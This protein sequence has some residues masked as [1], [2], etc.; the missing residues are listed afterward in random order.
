MVYLLL[1][2]HETHSVRGLSL[3]VWLSVCLSGCLSVCVSVW[4]LSV[5][6]SICLYVYLSA[7]L[8]VCLARNK[9]ESEL[10]E[11]GSGLH[12]SSPYYMSKKTCPNFFFILC[13][14]IKWVKASWTD[15]KANSAETISQLKYT[16]TCIS[17][18]RSIGISKY[19]LSYIF[20][21]S[22]PVMCMFAWA[23]FLHE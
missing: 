21:D 18:K 20:F 15:S 14:Q 16:I 13:Y 7:C 12:Q 10:A 17:L 19:F 23:I 3:C 1:F 6:L 11:L 9:S 4:L 22:P 5:C 2:Y 8:S